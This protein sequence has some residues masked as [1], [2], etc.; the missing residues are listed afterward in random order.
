MYEIV[1]SPLA[2]DDLKSIWHYS[3]KKWGEDKAVKYLLQ[4]DAGIQ[5]LTSNPEL[6][7]SR[8]SI[9][10]GYRSLQINRHVVYYRLQG[11]TID[12]VRVLH[13]RMLPKLHCRLPQSC[14]LF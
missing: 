13:E 4:L 6:G 12:S 10:A 9:R 5:G 14:P 2:K 3:F 11:Q 8:T 7:Q 1:N